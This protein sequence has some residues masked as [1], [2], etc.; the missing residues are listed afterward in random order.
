VL[1]TNAPARV[2]RQLVDISN[3][4]EKN[5]VLGA[6]NH[7]TLSAKKLCDFVGSAVVVKA[8]CKRDHAYD[9]NHA[10]QNAMRVLSRGIFS[11]YQ[12]LLFLL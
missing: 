8:I 2:S 11:W 5:T 9:G 3:L 10:H 12:W 7:G 1:A 6:G 4:D